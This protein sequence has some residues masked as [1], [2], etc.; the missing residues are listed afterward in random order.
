MLGS[1]VRAACEA[2]GHEP[3]AL[4]RGVLDICDE[5]SVQRAIA[6]ARPEVV[7]NCAAW[8]DVDGAESRRGRA[9]AVNGDGAG[10]VAR[11]GGAQW[12]VDDPRL[13]R[14]RVRRPQDDAVPRVRPRR[15]DLGLRPIEARRRARGRSR[16]ARQRTRSS[17]PR[18]SSAPRACFPATILRLAAERD[19]LDVVDRPVRMPDLHRPSRQGAGRSPRTRPLGL[20]HIAGA[21]QCSWFEFARGIVAHAGVDC[22]SRPIATAEYPRPRRVPPTACSPPSAARRAALPD[23]RE[24]LAAFMSESARCAHEAAR[25]WGRRLHR[26]DVRAP[27]RARARRRRDRARQAHLRGAAREPARRR[28]TRSASSRARS[29]IPAAVA[30]AVGAPTRS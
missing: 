18:G 4:P 1:D 8:T 20:L 10:N 21:G 19:E 29:R 25:L 9:V 22:V 23:W 26:L 14:L 27:A 3:V 13:D 24:G 17:V 30:D 15:P 7:I 5:T 16:R 28:A 2:A 11:G 12:G 6:Q